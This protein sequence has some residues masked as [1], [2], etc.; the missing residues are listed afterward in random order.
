MLSQRVSVM[1]LIDLLGREVFKLRRCELAFETAQASIG[2]YA[3][4]TQLYIVKPR[5]MWRH[6][7]PVCFGIWFA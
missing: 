4:L 7:S 2:A 6:L 3:V 5:S 1:C